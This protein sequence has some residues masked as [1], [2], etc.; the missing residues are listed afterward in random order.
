MNDFMENGVPSANVETEI[1]ST[2]LTFY[3]SDGD[4]IT[5]DIGGTPG[6][7][8]SLETPIATHVGEV[9]AYLIH[10]QVTGNGAN[11]SYRITGI[12]F[13]RLMDVE[14]NGGPS[15]RGVWIQPVA[16]VGLG[17]E[18]ATAAPPSTEGVGKLVLA[19]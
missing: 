15:N 19:R 13:G 1:G 2:T 5:Y 14:L 7:R 16:Y 6:L 9:I 10:D 12:R 3:D 8:A 17:V 11:T 4:P 18:T